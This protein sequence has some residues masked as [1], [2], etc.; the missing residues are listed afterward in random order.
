MEY[1]LNVGIVGDNRVGSFIGSEFA[2]EAVVVAIEFEGVNPSKKLVVCCP[3][4]GE[5]IFYRANQQTI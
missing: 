5:F 1:L 2:S 3:G 4:H